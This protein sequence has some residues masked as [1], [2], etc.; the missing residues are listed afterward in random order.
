MTLVNAAPQAVL[1]GADDQSNRQVPVVAEEIP[2]H[3]P[4]IPLFLQRGRHDVPVLCIGASADRTFGAESWSYDGPF[5]NHQTVLRNVINANGNS[6]YIRRLIPTGA[7]KAGAR[8]CIEVIESVNPVYL[9][10]SDGSFQLDANGAKVPDG[11]NTVNGYRARFVIRETENGIGAGVKQAGALRPHPSSG[12]DLITSQVI[13]LFDLGM[14]YGSY[15]SNVGFRLWDPLFSDEDP[16][17]IDGIENIGSF[18]YRLQLVERESSISTPA[19]T[20]TLDSERFVDFSFDTGAYNTDT[21]QKVDLV[22]KL[23]LWRNDEVR[24][25]IEAPFEDFHLYSGNVKDVLTMLAAAEAT[26][27]GMDVDVDT[28]NM[29]GGRDTEGVSYKSLEVLGVLDGGISLTADSTHYCIGGDD[30]DLSLESYDA[31]VAEHY[32]QFESDPANLMDMARW[33][34]S[35]VWDSGFSNETKEKLK[36]PQSLRKDIFTFASTQ[37]ASKAMNSASEDSSIGVSLRTM[38]ALSP[39]SSY[40]GTGVVR[41]CIVEGSGYLADGTWDGVLPLTIDLA[42]KVSKYWGAGN[43]AW[44]TG[45]SFFESPANHVSILKDINVTYRPTPSRNKDW[46]NGLMYVQSAGTNSLFYPAFPTVYSDKTSVLSDLRVGFALCTL[47]KYAHQAWVEL[48]GSDLDKA[49]FIE[50]SNSIITDKCSGMF[51]GRFVIEPET[52][53]T[54]LDDALGYTWSCNINLYANTTKYTGIYTI[55]SRRMEDLNNA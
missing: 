52:Y 12:S 31:A 16:L 24:P 25:M 18:L 20:P 8:F 9:R 40:Y 5:A 46:R 29:I 42:D 39:E 30:G 21:K 54:G 1:R 13:P 4:Y 3:A 6:Q 10:N 28:F 17:D 41:A 14:G 37:D 43:G 33:P 19:V 15:G 7:E 27:T 53:F 55:T 26:A 34:I 50:R 35:A 51:D 2:Q 44:K 32:S 36:I 47:E 48:S 22:T 23:G 49:K 38:F 45:S 11:T